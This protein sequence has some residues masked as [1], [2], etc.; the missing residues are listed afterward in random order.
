MMGYVSTNFAD[1]KI[2]GLRFANPPYTSLQ[3]ASLHAQGQMDVARAT[4]QP[5]GQISKNLSSRPAKNIPLNLSGK[6]VL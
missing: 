2:G 5:D 6:S 1:Q 4:K 3:T